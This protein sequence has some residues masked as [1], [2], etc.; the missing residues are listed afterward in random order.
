MAP[1]CCLIRIDRGH[2][3]AWRTRE[4]IR[5][6]E[7]PQKIAN[8]SPVSDEHDRIGTQRKLVDLVAGTIAGPSVNPGGGR[9]EAAPVRPPGDARDGRVR[10]QNKK[11]I[12]R[13]WPAGWLHQPDRLG[14]PTDK[15][16]IRVPFVAGLNRNLPTPALW[17]CIQLAAGQQCAC[18][19][20]RRFRCCD[21]FFPVSW[22]PFVVA[23]ILGSASPAFATPFTA[24]YTFTGAPGN[25]A[26]EPRRC[27]PDRR[28]VLG[29]HSRAGNQPERG[30]DF[31]QQ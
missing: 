15:S 26:S 24:T 28:D 21:A 18:H 5:R 29:H 1:L 13:S 14:L 12:R 19:P 31:D 7:V 16:S 23:V 6:T 20:H 9:H 27:K 3:S 30:H 10:D 22:C 17:A 11:A 25:Q 8:R 2:V 4:P